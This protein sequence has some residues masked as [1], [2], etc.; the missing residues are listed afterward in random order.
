ME[1]TSNGIRPWA[2]ATLVLLFISACSVTTPAPVEDRE[3]ELTPTEPEP[4][5]P[6]PDEPEVEPIPI[7]DLGDLR[8]AAQ[9]LSPDAPITVL[10]FMDRLERTPVGALRAL[11]RAPGTNASLGGWLDLTATVREAAVAGQPFPSAAAQWA[12]RWPAHPATSDDF[13]DLAE[14]WVANRPA[15]GPV[16]V[17][18]E[19]SGPLA[20]AAERMRDGLTAGYLDAPSGGRLT[21]YGLSS[22]ARSAPS[23]YYQAAEEGAQWIVGPLARPAVAALQNSIEPQMSTLYLNTPEATDDTARFP[24]ALQF[25]L[26]LSPEAEARAI[27]DLALSHGKRRAIAVVADS[28]RGDRVLTPFQ[29]AFEAGG[30]RVVTVVRF[31]PGA[32]EYGGLVGRALRTD[33]SRERAR[34]LENMLGE[35]VGFEPTRRSD[36]DLFFIATEPNEARLLLP[37]F[38]Y[39][40]AGN[41][42]VYAT[43]RIYS[44][45]PN[46][47]ADRDLEGV[48][49][50]IAPEQ[51]AEA[52]GSGAWGGDTLAALGADAWRLVRW[53]PLMQDDPDLVLHGAAGRWRATPFLALE[54]EPA[55]ARFRGGVPRPLGDDAR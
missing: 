18:L 29:Q 12:S 55:W 37:Q 36:F 45:R 27:A 16:A 31:D 35:E 11:A 6:E 19:T 20:S 24:G 40:D 39:H 46:G 8:E 3:P 50:S 44:G 42:P 23:A 43:G 34:A 51:L 26:S 25:A 2:W 54:R 38:K 49:F 52:T 14:R 48:M 17:L 41:V 15:V 53:L 47:V 32:A 21:Y 22:D 28:D 30:G 9:S 4:T 7:A 5:G 1:R 10:Q 13:I 33:A